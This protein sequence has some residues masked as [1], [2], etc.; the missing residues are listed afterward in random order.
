[1][2]ETVVAAEELKDRFFEWKDDRA[3]EKA[4]REKE[5]KRDQSR[6]K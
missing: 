3:E 1:V 6:E 2:N 5:K 4:K